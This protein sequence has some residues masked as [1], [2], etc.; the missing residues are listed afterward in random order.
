MFWLFTK[1]ANAIN[2]ASLQI[3]V[4]LTKL[5]LEFYTV[6]RRHSMKR[7]SY[8]QSHSEFHIWKFQLNKLH[9]NTVRSWLA[10]RVRS[11]IQR[12]KQELKTGKRPK[13][14]KT[15]WIEIFYLTVKYLFYD[16]HALSNVSM[17]KLYFA[18]MCVIETWVPYVNFS[19][20]NH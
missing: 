10:R 3:F 2:C 18:C 14:Q 6:D 11:T 9:K 13:V 7:M 5:K 17:S 12:P 15:F 19:C 4:T 8:F 16:F 20:I 1:Q